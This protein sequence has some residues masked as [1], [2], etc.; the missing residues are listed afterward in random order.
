MICIINNSLYFI[1]LPLIYK[2]NIE[3]NAIICAKFVVYKNPN[4]YLEIFP[5]GTI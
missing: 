4:E 1:L 2:Y 5:L 3:E